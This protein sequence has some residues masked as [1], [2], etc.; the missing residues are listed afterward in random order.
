ML[1]WVVCRFRATSFSACR[2]VAS[3]ARC[4]VVRL[5]AWCVIPGRPMASIGQRVGSGRGSGWWVRERAAWETGALFFAI[6]ACCEQ[7]AYTRGNLP[8]RPRLHNECDQP[9][10]AATTRA[11]QRELLSTRVMSLAQAIRKVSWQRGLSHES[12]R[13]P[14][15][16][17]RAACPPTAASRRLPIFPFLM[18]LDGGPDLVIRGEHPRLVSS[19]QA[20]PVLPRR[21]PRRR[22]GAAA[23]GITARQRRRT[24]SVSVARS[25]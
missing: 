5:H 25:A 9:D 1:P 11:L 19:R 18:G 24:F 23:R 2:S 17:P 3:L 14:L 7:R 13:S 15:A 6:R 4:I 22:R 8:D 20:V 10:V 21:R 12:Q 16:A